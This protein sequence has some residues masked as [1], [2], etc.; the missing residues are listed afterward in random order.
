MDKWWHKSFLSC[1]IER[2]ALAVVILNLVEGEPNRPA[3]K[4]QAANYRFPAPAEIV[5]VLD[6]LLVYARGWYRKE[7][8]RR[9]FQETGTT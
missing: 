6:E 7:V 1:Q 3:M 2:S 5:G 8:K 4:A 9:L